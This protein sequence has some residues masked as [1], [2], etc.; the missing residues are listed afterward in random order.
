MIGE[1]V[2][3]D[4]ESE[5]EAPEDRE[6]A[7]DAAPPDPCQREHDRGKHERDLGGIVL[8][9]CDRNGERG[10]EQRRHG[11][12]PGDGVERAQDQHAG[13]EAEHDDRGIL[14]ELRKVQPRH[15]AV[16]HGD[17]LRRLRLQ[18]GEE[19]HGPARQHAV[20]QELNQQIE[21]RAQSAGHKAERASPEFARA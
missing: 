16:L 1:Q 12:R 5:T 8:R 13:P 10:R 6:R 11:D 20:A 3:R 2:E 15:L 18:R 21:R 7:D 9:E 19:I 14:I 4:D 17:V